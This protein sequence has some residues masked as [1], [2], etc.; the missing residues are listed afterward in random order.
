MLVEA[1][2]DGWLSKMRAG[3]SRW[4][5]WH[6]ASCFGAFP[7]RRRRTQ[8]RRYWRRR[9]VA[10]R[11]YWRRPG[12]AWGQRHCVSI[13]CRRIAE[14]RV[15]GRFTCVID[16]R[17][18]RGAKNSPGE[19][20]AWLTCLT[21]TET[22][23]SASPSHPPAGSRELHGALVLLLRTLLATRRHTIALQTA[24]HQHS[25]LHLPLV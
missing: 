13:A 18:G 4:E 21:A 22:G 23:P 17:I 11:T 2:Q 7:V 10:P 8:R 5:G 19:A 15:G 12:E 24:L 14:A 6:P 1:G 20:V 9:M 16:G 3:G 25:T